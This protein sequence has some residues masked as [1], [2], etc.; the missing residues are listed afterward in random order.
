MKIFHLHGDNIVE[1]E[2]TIDLIRKA[3]GNELANF[4][5]PN[6]SP[7]CPTYNITFADGT[8]PIEI[9]LYPGFGKDRWNY[10]ILELIRH[11]G[12]TLREAADVIITVVENNEEIP[13]AAIEYCGAL[14]AGNQAWQRSGRAYSFGKAKIPYLYIAELGGYELGEG[15][16]RKAPRMPNPAVPFSYLSYS[17]T[18]NTLTLPVFVAAAGADEQSR[19][20]FADVFAEPELLAFIRAIILGENYEAIVELLRLKT[21]T[22]VKTKAETAQIGKSLTPIQW[23]LAYLALERDPI[24]INFLVDEGRLNWSKT[25]YI[26]AITQT[27]KILMYKTSVIAIGMTS[28]ELPMCIIPKEKRL[29]FANIVTYLYNGKIHNEFLSWLRRERNLSICWVNGFKPKGDDARPDR[30]LPPFTR[31]LAGENED[32]LTV[33]YG[34]AS[35]STWQDLHHNPKQ[36][37]NNGLWESIFEISDALL[38][39]SSTDKVNQHGYLRTHWNK[40]STLVT[41]KK[42]IVEPKP[43]QIGENDVDTVIHLLL[44]HYAGASIFEGMCNP[45]G[46]DWSGIS[47]QSIDRTLELRWLTLPRVSPIG[48]KRPDHVFQLFIPESKPILICIESKETAAS[49]ESGIGPRLTGY[50]SHLLDTTASVSRQTATIQWSHTTLSLNKKDF[51]MASAVAFKS[52][53]KDKTDKVKERAS[54]DILMSFTFSNG[55]DFCEIKLTPTSQIG[56]SIASFIAEIP[57]DGKN[58]QIEIDA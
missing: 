44:A 58:I 15:R 57:L 5:G 7:V 3:L 27:A 56:K 42:S 21:L 13:V 6:G 51:L 31:M 8:T 32:I 43:L 16:K 38:I 39:D 40:S 1:C 23:E 36:L 54:A 26:T 28:S 49:V 4:D 14:P 55:G 2:R 45:P 11:Q 9:T 30:G 37:L 53:S 52:D 24:L 17:L 10:N 29:E 19:D 48:A 35:N 22:F 50:I 20:D 34:P 33:V 18:N 47:F 12:G 46:G 25:A 41:H